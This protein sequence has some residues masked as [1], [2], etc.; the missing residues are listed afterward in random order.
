MKAAVN[1]YCST[2]KSN[3]LAITLSVLLTTEKS[4]KADGTGTIDLTGL[5]K[6]LE[7]WFS[8]AKPSASAKQF[9]HGGEFLFNLTI[10]S[11]FDTN[12]PMFE[13]PLLLNL[14]NIKGL[15]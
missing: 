1:R 9:T 14:T 12:I 11:N 6:A 13:L 10:F 2:L 3:G 7:K 15:E 4:F 8:V 5:S